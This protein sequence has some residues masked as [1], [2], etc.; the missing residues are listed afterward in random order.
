ML[1]AIVGK[2]LEHFLGDYV[3]G[4]DNLSLSLGK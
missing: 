4:L 2:V 3:E 1:D